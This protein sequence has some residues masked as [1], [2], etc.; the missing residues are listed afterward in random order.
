M[1]QVL[2]QFP[3]THIT[4]INP[5]TCT[6]NQLMHKVDLLS[7]IEAGTRMKCR[8]GKSVCVCFKL[9]VIYFFFLD[10]LIDVK[11]RPWRYISRHDKMYLYHHRMS[12]LMKCWYTICTYLRWRVG[13]PKS[14]RIVRLSVVNKLSQV[15][16]IIM[17]ATIVCNL[18]RDPTSNLLA[19]SS[20]PR[21]IAAR[22]SAGSLMAPT[23]LLVNKTAESYPMSTYLVAW[24]QCWQLCG[25][26]V[27]LE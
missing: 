6:P 23:L 11:L 20:Q 4:T 5:I 14:F 12:I 21:P 1:A 17:S 16:N 7:N 22:K 24:G 10:S 26:I 19:C 25:R 3:N 27:H 8:M 13:I 9:D 2:F 15:Y 18:S